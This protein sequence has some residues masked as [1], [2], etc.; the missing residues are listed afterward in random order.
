MYAHIHT[1]SCIIASIL[2]VVI[3]KYSVSFSLGNVVTNINSRYTSLVGFYVLVAVIMK[4]V[5]WELKPCS[6]VEGYHNFGG[7]W[8]LQL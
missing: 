3:F 1:G 4:V 8:G 6:L 2:Y 5:F 7:M